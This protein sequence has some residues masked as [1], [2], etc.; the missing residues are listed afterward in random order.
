MKRVLFSLN[1]PAHYHMFKNLALQLGQE[2]HQ[3]IFVI[4]NKDVLEALLKNEGANYVKLQDQRPRKS[5]AFSV[6][7]NGVADML[8]KDRSL[9]KFAKQWKPDIMLGTDISITHVGWVTGIPSF[10][11]NEDDYDINKAAC[12]LSYPFAKGIVSP[13]VCSVGKYFQKK[14][15]TYNGCQK[16]AYINPASFKP[17]RSIADKFVA[18]DKPYYLIRV[19]SL[20][21]GHDISGKHRGIEDDIL[22][23]LIS[24][25]SVRGNVYISSERPLP[26]A[27]ERHRLQIPPEYMHHIMSFSSLFIGDS[28]SMC[29]EAGLMGVPFIRYNDFVGKIGYLN[30]AEIK[31]GLGYGVRTSEPQKMIELAKSLI[32]NDKLAAQWKE[33]RKRY[34]SEKVDVTAF[35]KW[36]VLNYPESSKI[37]KDDPKYPDKFRWPS[38]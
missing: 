28:Q 32:E 27:Y 11:F 1:H 12:L 30:D 26:E 29:M 23:Q 36:F 24:L 2:G 10:F 6:I 37:L 33:K 8:E 7:T 4:S 13:E 5:T 3:V 14:K 22:S 25:L 17:D 31:Y 19:V 20:T 16:T 21:A 38:F 18:K 35:W 15:I 9:Y 34:F